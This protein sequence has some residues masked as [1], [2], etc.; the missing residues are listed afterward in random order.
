MPFIPQTERDELDPG[1]D[2]LRFDI[3]SVGQRTYVVYRLAFDPE[4]LHGSYTSMSHARAVLKDAY[5]VLTERLLKYERA[6][7]EEN[8]GI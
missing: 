7:E 6:K 8:G 1:I 4:N 3:D 5:D 2:T